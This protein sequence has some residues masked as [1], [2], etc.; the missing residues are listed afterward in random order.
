MKKHSLAEHHEDVEDWWRGNFVII[1]EA[2]RQTVW[3]TAY[4]RWLNDRSLLTDEDVVEG[5]HEPA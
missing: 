1:S 2:A 4:E 3:F 5:V